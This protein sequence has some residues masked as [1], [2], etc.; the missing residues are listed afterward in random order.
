MRTNHLTGTEFPAHTTL[1]FCL[2]N[3]RGAIKMDISRWVLFSKLGKLLQKVMS[4]RVRMSVCANHQGVPV[5]RAWHQLWVHI[6]VKNLKKRNVENPKRV[7]ITGNRDHC[8]FSAKKKYEKIPKLN[9]NKNWFL[10]QLSPYNQCKKNI[11]IFRS[12]HMTHVRLTYR[13]TKRLPHESS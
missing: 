12:N 9:I 7:L 8:F 5:Q 10:T 3:Y 2:H 13:Y 1:I 4:V 6:L 11:H